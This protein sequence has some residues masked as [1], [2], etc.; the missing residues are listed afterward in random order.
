[1]SEKVVRMERR[2]KKQF[3]LK[4]IWNL[5]IGPLN[6]KTVNGIMVRNEKTKKLQLNSEI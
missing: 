1:M 5:N 3:K 4:N 6:L 2:R